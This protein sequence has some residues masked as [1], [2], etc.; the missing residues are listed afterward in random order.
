ME[1][2]PVI[3]VS[4]MVNRFGALMMPTQNVVGEMAACT[5]SRYSG[6]G[7]SS[8]HLHNNAP[9]VRPMKSAITVSSG[10]A[11]TSPITRG[12]IRTSCGST[13]MA[14]RASTSSLSFI[15]PI[16]AANALPERPATMMAVS[17]TASSRSTLMVM[18]STT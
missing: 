9:P 6:N 3:E 18:R 15:A 13:P 4:G 14:C 12:R 8:S 5:R 11:M 10:S 1:A 16:S 17:N 2:T 7:M